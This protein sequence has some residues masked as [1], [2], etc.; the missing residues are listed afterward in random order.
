MRNNKSCWE[1]KVKTVNCFWELLFSF[2]SVEIESLDSLLNAIA[3]DEICH[4]QRNDSVLEILVRERNQFQVLSDDVAPVENA[5]RRDKKH[6]K[7]VPIEFLILGQVFH[8]GSARV[9]DS[10]DRALQPPLVKE[11]HT[12][13]NIGFE[14][15]VRDQWVVLGSVDVGLT[16]LH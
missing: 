6:A 11:E 14:F 4:E 8:E 5:A 7:D 13:L 16:Q 9:V 10:N 15:S 1:L 2:E 12:V 3:Y